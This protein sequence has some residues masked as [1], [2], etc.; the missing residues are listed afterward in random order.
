MKHAQ[1]H[2]VDCSRLVFAKRLNLPSHLERHRHAQLFLDTSPY[3]AH[4]TASDALWAD[5][6]VLTL[7]GRSFASRVC[8]SLLN[9]LKMYDF[10]CKTDKEYEEQAVHWVKNKDILDQQREKLKEAKKS[11]KLFRGDLFAKSLE[12]AYSK[13][14]SQFE[15]G[16]GFS[17]IDLTN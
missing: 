13:M 10:I 4:T 5:L 3:N 6:L 14:Y 16:G 2:H 17:S 11:S 1:R 9:E 7:V 8:A 12:M 15:R